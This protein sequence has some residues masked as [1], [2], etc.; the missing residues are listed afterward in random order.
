MPI[1]V[2]RLILVFALFVGI[3]IVLIQLLTPKSF[4]QFGHYRGDALKEIADK[5]PKYVGSQTCA[6]CHDSLSTVKDSSFHKSINCETCHGPGNKHAEDPVLN[7]IEKPVGRAFCIRCHA[8]NPARPEKIIKQI[9]AIEH[10][11]G[12]VCITCHN[13]HNPWQ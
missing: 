10:N 5:E 2:K 6:M 11:K 1:H 3:M 12:E 7:K 4:K 8:K 9:N 13:P